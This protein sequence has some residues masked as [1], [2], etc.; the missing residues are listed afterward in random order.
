MRDNHFLERMIHGLDLDTEPLPGAPL[1]EIIGGE[2]VLIE[3]HCGMS[4]YGQSQMCVKVKNGHI[5]VCG[6]RLH[7]AQMSRERLVICGCIESVRLIR[8]K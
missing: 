5:C 4:E 8:G 6:K 2:R 7:L 1:L 3:N